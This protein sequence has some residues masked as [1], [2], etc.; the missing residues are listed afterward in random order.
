M[1]T[2][3]TLPCSNVVARLFAEADDSNARLEERRRAISSSE[4][5]RLM[6]STDNY[7]SLYEDLKEF[8]L[9]VARETAVLLYVL[10]RSSRARTIV[11]FGTSFGVSTLHLG[12]ALRDNGGRRLIGTEFERTK[13]AQA[14]ANIAAAGLGDLVEVRAGDALE[15]LATDLPETIDL[16]LLDGAK[17]LYPKV[18]SLLEPRLRSGALVVAD[19]ADWSPEYLARVRNPAAGYLSVPFA[20][21]VELSL[22]L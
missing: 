7:Q 14:R 18:L 21:D 17:G 8:H 19:N 22:K 13:I 3:T 1:N 6:T 12:A 16:V 4:H 10:A 2:L 15:T 5:A 20:S 9:A 11:E